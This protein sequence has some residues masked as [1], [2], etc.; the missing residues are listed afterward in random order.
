MALVSKW[1]IWTLYFIVF[2][3]LFQ[4]TFVFPFLPTLVTSFGGSAQLISSRVG[5]LSSLAAVGEMIGSPLLGYASDKYGRRPVLLISTLGSAG[6]AV[7]LGFCKTFEM[8][9]LARI[10]NGLSGG[11][12]GIANTYLSDVTTLEERPGYMSKMTGFIG[13]GLALGP[14][15]GGQ[16]YNLG[17]IEV[18]CLSAGAISMLNF[19]CILFFLQESRETRL[20]HDA[21]QAAQA[22]SGTT[23]AETLT[24]VPS[25]RLP[26]KLWIL[27]FASFFQAPIS[28][29]FDT[30]ANL[31]VTEKFYDGDEKKGTILFSNCV[32]C[33]GV[34]L[35][36]V[37]LVLYQ[38]FLRCV[39]FNGSIVAGTMTIVFGLIC[40]GFAPIPWMFLGSTMI[41]AFGFQLMGPAVPVLISR[42]VKSTDTGKAFGLFNSF[43]NASRVIG[44]TALTPLYNLYHPSV[45]YFLGVSMTIVG[46]ILLYIS[47]SMPMM[48]PARAPSLVA[49]ESGQAETPDASPRSVKSRFSRQMS[50]AG[51]SSY[52]VYGCL[53]WQREEVEVMLGEARIP[54][55]ERSHTAPQ[56]T[57]LQ[58]PELSRTASC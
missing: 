26:C 10:I 36:I 41:W 20:A 57:L 34:C 42:M 28:V 29:V 49:E 3:D 6:S 30:F 19:C 43:G 17:G 18:A 53:P 25:A 52:Q 2:V 33:I 51:Q 32:A 23:A 56:T 13:I 14:I 9:I 47:K 4:I 46:F 45:F 40:N 31:Y 1:A 48:A 21:A 39:G 5:Y 22:A 50:G 58:R 35:L 24:A 55:L 38:P 37:P 11:T 15:V 7:L 54:R 8:A 27:F 44:P 16:L 12:A